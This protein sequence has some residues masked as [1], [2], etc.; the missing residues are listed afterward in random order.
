MTNLTK[1]HPARPRLLDTA[2]LI[3]AIGNWRLLAECQFA[4]PD[5][6][7]PISG[8]GSSVAQADVAKDFCARCVVQPECLAFA[9]RTR[10][11]HGIWGGLTEEERYRSIKAS[12]LTAAPALPLPA[13]P[14]LGRT[15]VTAYVAYRPAAGLGGPRT[16]ARGP[17]RR[18]RGAA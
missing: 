7:F 2:Q 1:A 3:A 16:G 13:P 15:Y 9:L 11:V 10:Q 17:R 18:H 14:A 4:D 8:V 12:A 6:F 5:L